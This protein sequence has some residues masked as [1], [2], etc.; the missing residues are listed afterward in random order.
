MFGRV[1]TRVAGALVGVCAAFAA[2]V[3]VGGAPASA[4]NNGGAT[5]LIQLFTLTPAGS[6]WDATIRIVDSDLGTPVR[7][8]R[9]FALHGTTPTELSPGSTPGSYQGAVAG[10][11]PGAQTVGVKVQSQ[12]SGDP[13]NPF[14]QTWNVTL[15]AGQ[16][17]SVVAGGGGGGGSNIGM[18]LGVAGAVVLVALLYGLFTVRRRT[19]VPAGRK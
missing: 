18:I 10:V 14:K 1:G 16:P 8:A 15:A 13:V 17:L 12:P 2:V 9:V 19:A 4:H 11:Q 7:G 3:G 5:P 6:S